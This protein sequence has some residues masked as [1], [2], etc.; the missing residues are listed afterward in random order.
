MLGNGAQALPE[1]HLNIRYNP[2]NPDH[3]ALDY[4]G[5]NLLIPAVLLNAVLMLI[6]LGYFT[7]T[8]PRLKLRGY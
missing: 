1:L 5:F 7:R 4:P 3:S 8:Y 6:L 2:G